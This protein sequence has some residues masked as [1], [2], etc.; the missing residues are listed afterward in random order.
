MYIK[1]KSS[2]GDNTELLDPM[3]GFRNLVDGEVRYINQDSLSV[4]ED[5]LSALECCALSAQI[6]KDNTINANNIE[7]INGTHNLHPSYEFTKKFRAD[8][9]NVAI[10]TTYYL[11]NIFMAGLYDILF[12]DLDI[13]KPFSSLMNNDIFVTAQLLMDNDVND[14]YETLISVG[15]DKESV[16]KVSY[17]INL[18][19]WATGKMDWH[20]NFIDMP[21]ETTMLFKLLDPLGKANQFKKMLKSAR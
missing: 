21:F 10:P 15:W 2:D 3:G 6:E 4:E 8:V 11:N 9:N 16:I 19:K 12:P 7:I 20:D 18:T 5:P 17:L 13:T 14:V 1:I